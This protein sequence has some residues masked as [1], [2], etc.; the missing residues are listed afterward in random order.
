MTIILTDRRPK[1]RPTSSRAP[2]P[3]IEVVGSIPVPDAALSH[4]F[5]REAVGVAMLH[6]RRDPD[7]E[8]RVAGTSNTKGA[9]L[10]GWGNCVGKHVDNT[11]FM[12]LAPLT[13]ARSTLYALHADRFWEQRLH[14]GQVVRLWDWAPHWTEDVGPVVAAFVGAFQQPEDALAVQIL[15]NAVATLARG[16]YEG[17]PRVSPGYRVV[18]DDECWATEHFR[19]RD[20]VRLMLRRDAR[21][22]GMHVIG[23]AQCKRPAV[24]LDNLWP[25]SWELNRCR[26]HRVIA[27]QPEVA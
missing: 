27:S 19:D 8:N 6:D 17:A 24:T 26:A 1:V 16:E 23:C 9:E 11:G 13:V 15:R 2:A 22:R 14:V 18:M 20:D 5:C 12:Y 25:Y 7:S 4:R 21:R 3:V 10:Y